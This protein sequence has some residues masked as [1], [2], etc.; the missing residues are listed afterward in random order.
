MNSTRYFGSFEETD[1][2]ILSLKVTTPKLSNIVVAI[3]I[4]ESI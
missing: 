2:M 1:K 4:D 3:S